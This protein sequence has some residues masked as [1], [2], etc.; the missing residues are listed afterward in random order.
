VASRPRSFTRTY[1]PVESANAM[2]GCGASWR[3]ALGPRPPK[4]EV[5]W[6]DVPS[7]VVRAVWTGPQVSLSAF[8]TR[9]GWAAKK[10]HD[11]A[12]VVG[13]AIAFAAILAALAGS[14]FSARMAPPPV[15][16]RAAL[17]GMVMV[18]GGYA[19]EFSGWHFPPLHEAGRMSAVH[20]GATLGA[21]TLVAALLSLGWALV[22]RRGA[23]LAVAVLASAYLASL[24][25][26]R[27]AVQR[28]FGPRPGSN[29]NTG[30]AS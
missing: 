21:A 11:P 26:Y 22:R 9:P 1:L 30:H 14:G 3:P 28:G 6:A 13:M 10:Y 4:W 25:G 7:R 17:T 24:F 15:L 19:L 16:L 29:G 5:T 18:A 12:F 20:L 8:V 2:C 27:L 23:Q